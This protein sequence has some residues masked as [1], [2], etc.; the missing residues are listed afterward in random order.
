MPA[1][2]S[3]F[4]APTAKLPNLIEEAPSATAA[5]SVEAPLPLNALSSPAVCEIEFADSKLES[6]GLL[7]GSK[8]G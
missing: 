8:A 1:T 2:P 6:R 7:I 4:R 3:V 5:A